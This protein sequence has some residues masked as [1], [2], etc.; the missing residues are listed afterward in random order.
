M[1]G[2]YWELPADTGYIEEDMT[3]FSA[4]HTFPLG[5]CS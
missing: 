3:L 5:F 1:L 4:L 2:R